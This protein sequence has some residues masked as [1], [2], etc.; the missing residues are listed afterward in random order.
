[1]E[2]IPKI[3]NPENQGENSEVG[4][5]KPPKKFQF[6]PGVSGNPAGRP[7]GKSLKEYTR[8]YLQSMTEEERIDFLNGLD[9][10][11]VWRMTEGNPPQPLELEGKG[12]LPFIIQIIKGDGRDT[13]NTQG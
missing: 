3:I 12:G 1:M 8:E 5:R 6:K 11:M 4:N 10:A 7:K 2:E 13:T 9:P